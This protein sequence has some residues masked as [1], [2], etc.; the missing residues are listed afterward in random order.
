MRDIRTLEADRPAITPLID[1]AF[2]M[3]IFFMALPYKSLDRKLEAHLPRGEG[4][5]PRVLDRDE[6]DPK[7]EIRVRRTADG[8]RFRVGVHEVREAA[9]LIPVLRQLGVGYRYEIHA[10]SAAAWQGVVQAV[11]VL[12]A[13]EYPQINF[14]GCPLP[15]RD[16]RVA[17]PLPRP[18]GYQPLAE[19]K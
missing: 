8:H 19:A 13:L 5:E 16:V 4:F 11:D 15:E 3:L 14:R 7:V 12:R 9:G 10:D 17:R 2:L 1:I 6:P 18:A